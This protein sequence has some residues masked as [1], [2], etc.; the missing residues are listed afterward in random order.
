MSFALSYVEDVFEP[1]NK[2]SNDC[3][4]Q[5]GTEHDRNGPNRNAQN[6][7]SVINKVLYWTTA[8]TTETAIVHLKQ[9]LLPL[10]PDPNFKEQA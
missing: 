5:A 7:P 2:L 3:N 10:P 9:R 1:V 6:Q 4:R 8:T